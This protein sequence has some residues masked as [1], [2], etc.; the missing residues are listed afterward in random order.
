MNR[1]HTQHVL[2]KIPI[3]NTQCVTL[4]SQLT[5]H[6]VNSSER[7]VFFLKTY[8][9]IFSKQ[10]IGLTKQLRGI[11][12]PADTLLLENAHMPVNEI[13][14]GALRKTADL[15]FYP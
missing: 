14:Y 1:N 10:V 4:K 3:F 8:A 11:I 13:N 12:Q 2:N 6:K 7:G 15:H 5:R 9:Q